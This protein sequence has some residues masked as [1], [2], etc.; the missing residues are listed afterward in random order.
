[1]RWESEGDNP[2]QR[3][4]ITAGRLRLRPGAL[5]AWLNET[6]FARH[7]AAPGDPYEGPRS[8]GVPVELGAA[9]GDHEALYRNLAAA[10]EGRE[11]L[12][13]PGREA[14]AALE[15]AN[16]ALYSGATGREVVLPLDRSE[17][18][19]FLDGRRREGSLWK[20]SQIDS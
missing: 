12:L 19:A 10:L 11:P 14:V 4:I 2:C 6:D 20:R 13:A 15:L 7:A 8:R 17:Y 5:E 18:T 1:V 16:A 3:E 9:G